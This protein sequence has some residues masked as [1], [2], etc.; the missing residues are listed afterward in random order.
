MTFLYI[1]ALLFFTNT[2]TK[3][4][5]IIPKNKV[6]YQLI[7]IELSTRCRTVLASSDRILIAEKLGF[8]KVYIDMIIRRERSAPPAVK[9][10]LEAI[11]ARILKKLSK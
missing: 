11:S 7:D 9:K 8:T 3:K 5:N 4:T 6:K 2:M 10:Q 1:F